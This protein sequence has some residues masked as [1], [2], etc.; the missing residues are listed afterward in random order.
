MTPQSEAIRLLNE[1]LQENESPKGSLS[2]AVQ[3]LSRAATL[4][5]RFDVQKWCSIQL[6]DRTFTRPL[7]D[8]VEA[9]QSKNDSPNPAVATALKKL[10]ELELSHD[11]HFRA[12]ELN[13][14]G[15]EGS[16]GYS[17][18]GFV[19][20]RYADLVRLKRGNDGTYYKNHLNTHIN[21]VR[22]R[23]HELASALLSQLQFAG[24][25]SSCFD[26]LKSAVDDRL[27]DMN[28]SLAEQLMLAFKGVSSLDKEE[29]SQALTTCRRLLEAV[30]DAVHPA[31][32]DPIQGRVITQA[33]YVN[34]LWA[35]MDKAIESDSNRALAK[36][37]VDFLGSWM[38]KTNKIANKGVHAEL[39]QLEAVKSV[40]HVYLVLAD[41][42]EYLNAEPKKRGKINI[43]EA[44]MD[45]LE[46]ALDVSRTVAKAIFKAR[47]SNGTL[48]LAIL[49][50]VPGVGQK[51]VEK[52]LAEFSF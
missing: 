48:D 8:L 10:G 41:I 4:I 25:T 9:L 26:L 1:S 29:W 3:K 33:Q 24:A 47:M 20:E 42:L 7:M 50:K 46:A 15:H 16:G 17:S 18:I 45:E 40:F 35:F 11:M 6:G 2:A 13:I 19:Q 23:S 12:E 38:E 52:A 37:H 21:Y 31:N 14:K 43:N 22:R 5:K 30:A 27:L 51:T 34:R 39:G 32:S 44:S 36:S 28:P 49:K